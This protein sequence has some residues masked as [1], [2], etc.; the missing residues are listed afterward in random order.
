MTGAESLSK[1]NND[2]LITGNKLAR[3]FEAL[4][5]S[6]GK[7]AIETGVH[8]LEFAHGIIIENRFSYSLSEI[9][10]ALRKLLG[11]SAAD[12]LRAAI[13]MHLSKA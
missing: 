11:D 13:V 10:G 5:K 9:D 1:E 7:S 2:R 3:C 12:L 4:K 6:P 8:E